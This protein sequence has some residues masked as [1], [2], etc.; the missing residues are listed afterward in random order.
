MKISKA[1]A[2]ANRAALVHAASRLFREKGLDGTG[3]AEICQAAGLTAGALYSHFPSQDALAAEALAHGQPG[4]NTLARSFFSFFISIFC[5][6]SSFPWR[7]P[8]LF[9]NPHLPP[10]ARPPSPHTPAWP[11]GRRCFPPRGPGPAPT[12][13]QIPTP[14]ARH[15][16][17]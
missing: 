8:L 16:T 13:A 11:R 14:A 17:A 9:F 10:P 12:P 2:E 1:Q 3:I 4:S 7:A 5:S 15:S 6:C